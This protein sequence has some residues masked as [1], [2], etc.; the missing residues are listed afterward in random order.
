MVVISI[1][2]LLSLLNLASCRFGSIDTPPPT[3][4][5]GNPVGLLVSSPQAARDAALNHLQGNFDF[6]SFTNITWSGSEISTQETA[7]SKTFLYSGNDW[8]VL[9]SYPTIIS[10]DSV[11]NV[12]VINDKVAF[13][14]QGLVDVYGNVWTTSVD[15]GLIQPT[16][17]QP[18]IA[19]PPNTT[20]PIP[21]TST[22]PGS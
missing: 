9:V 19:S 12:T 17:T 1:V 13:E 8:I 10:V 7:N 6:I 21:Y 15:L 5:P 22:P 3:H 14:W 4:T 20:T 2:F 16:A 11:I 18:A